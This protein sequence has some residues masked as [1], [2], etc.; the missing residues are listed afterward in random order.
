MTGTRQSKAAVVRSFWHG[1]ELGPYQQLCLASFV[2]NG[3]RAEIFCYDH[4]LKTPSW[5]ERRDANEI[6]PVQTVLHYQ[7]GFGRGSPALHA[8]FFRYEMLYALGGWWIDCDMLMLDTSLP[9]DT[10]FMAYQQDELCGNSILRFPAG[11]ALLSAAKHVCEQVGEAVT[12]W[13]QT[14]PYLLTK[15]LQEYGLENQVRPATAAYPIPW[16]DVPVF[17]DPDRADEVMERCRQSLAVHLFN[18][19]WRGAGVPYWLGPPPGSFLDRMFRRLDLNPKFT[20]RMRYWEIERWINNRNQVIILQRSTERKQM[21]YDK[22][23]KEITA[24]KNSTTWTMTRPARRFV[25]L[26]RRIGH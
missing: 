2:A 7:D 8:N 23:N 21:E 22:L 15:L 24:I 16:T 26:I 12:F 19:V 10:L 25:E 9:H 1:G 6:L 11:H 3:F 13:G 4:N 17:F 5:I 14:G 20:D 18:E